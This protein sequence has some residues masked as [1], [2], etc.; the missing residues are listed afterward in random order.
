MGDLN[1]YFLVRIF[2]VA[3]ESSHCLHRDHLDEDPDLL[4]LH[5]LAAGLRA[6]GGGAAHEGGRR[7][8]QAAEDQGIRDRWKARGC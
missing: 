3:F 6:A 7:T 1:V 4:D 8:D 2:T 5:H